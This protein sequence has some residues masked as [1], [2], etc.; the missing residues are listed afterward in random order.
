MAE[1]DVGK[2]IPPDDILTDQF[3]ERVRER[4][5]EAVEATINSRCDDLIGAIQAKQA[6]AT[7]EI[8]AEIDRITADLRAQEAQV[9]E[10]FM[11]RIETVRSEALAIDRETV[12]RQVITRMTP[13]VDLLHTAISGTFSN[14]P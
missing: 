13:D 9:S 11:Q 12:V 2:L 10:P 1:H 3:G 5:E 8:R 4:A 14:R 7:K 6:E